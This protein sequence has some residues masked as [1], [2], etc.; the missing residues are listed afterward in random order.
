MAEGERGTGARREQKHGG[1]LHGG[2]FDAEAG[3]G[4]RTQGK[5]VEHGAEEAKPTW[6]KQASRGGSVVTS[7]EERGHAPRGLLLGLQFEGQK[8]VCFRALLRLLHGGNHPP[9]SAV[10]FHTK[11][12]SEGTRKKGVVTSMEEPHFGTQKGGPWKEGGYLHGGRLGEG[13]G[14][15]REA[16]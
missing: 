15:T 10:F 11:A 6:G 12:P 1:Y 13:Q 8:R 5:L 4:R 16:R 3:P 14:P 9:G 2:E 7:M